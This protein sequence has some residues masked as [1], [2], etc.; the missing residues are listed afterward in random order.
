MTL[1]ELKAECPELV[2]A[3]R[4][5]AVKEG[6][7][8]ERTRI[9]AIEEIA[10][11]GHEDLVM[12]AKFGEQPMTAEQ[13]AMAILKAEMANKKTALAARV[14]DAGE[15]NAVP[16]AVGNEGIEPTAEKPKTVA[17]KIAEEKALFE[18]AKNL[19]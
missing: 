3:I 1:E 13:L 8:Q 7:A 10:M 15:L 2:E 19:K 18:A 11:A 4:A 14:K 9:K 6:A 12:S 5:E 17:E 16:S